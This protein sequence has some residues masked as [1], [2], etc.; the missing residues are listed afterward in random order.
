MADRKHAK[1]FQTGLNLP[2]KLQEGTAKDPARIRMTYIDDS[3]MKG[4]FNVVCTWWVGKSS[5]KSLAP[6]THDF[7]EVLGF[8]GSDT[9]NPHDLGGEI[10]FWLE[11]EQYIYNTSF[12][13]FIPKGMK[14][15]PLKLLKIERPI[16][17]VG[18]MRTGE[19]SKEDK[20]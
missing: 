8:Y 10:E 13:V 12:C 19:Y 18:I 17:H 7:D 9:Q 11:D 4:A 5:G 6:H 2:A 14:H 15:C 20:A 16:F 3:V 1:Y